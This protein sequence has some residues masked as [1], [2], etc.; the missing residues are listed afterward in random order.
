VEL[1]VLLRLGHKQSQIA[2]QL[3]VHR[4]TIG[5]EIVRNGHS[6]KSGYNAHIAQAKAKYRRRTANR[7]RY[8][9]VPGSFLAQY[10]ESALQ[11]GLV[12]EQVAGR[13]R[14]V[15]GHGPV[16]CETIYRW[17]YLDRPDLKHLL[18]SAKRGYRRKRGT[19]S[20]WIKRE[21]DRKRHIW[22]RPED[23][24]LRLLVGDWEGDTVHGARHEGFLATLVERVSGY[25]LARKLESNTATAFREA[26]QIMYQDIPVRLRRTLTLDNG[27]EMNEFEALEEKTGTTVY[28]ARPYHS[29]ERGTNENTNGLLRQYF[30]KKQSMSLVTQ[31]DVDRAVQRLNT[32]PRKRLGYQSPHTVFYSRVAFR[33]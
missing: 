23:V 15:L 26:V 29:W 16:S 13:L 33:D 3:Q 20:R 2:S 14:F 11:Y 10:C 22:Q 25:T 21:H 7:R 31:E 12:P 24:E 18:R 27:S 9:I 17:I 1:G 6:N 4:C 5:R 8:R 30:P 32:R 28:F 19:N